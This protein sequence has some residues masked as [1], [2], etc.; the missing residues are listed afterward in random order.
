[1][2]ERLLQGNVIH[3]DMQVPLHRLGQPP[4][5]G[6]VDPASSTPGVQVDD[7]DLVDGFHHGG[8]HL[9]KGVVKHDAIAGDREPPA[10]LWP[11]RAS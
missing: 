1:M 4:G 11:H 2:N 3:L 9:G 7:G 6:A 8:V 5:T 10:H